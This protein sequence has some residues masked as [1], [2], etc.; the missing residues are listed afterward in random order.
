V[1]DEGRHLAP[2]SRGLSRIN[3][4][5]VVGGVLAILHAALL[6]PSRPPVAPMLGELMGIVVMPYL[7]M[8]AA[9]REASRKPARSASR[10]ISMP[11]VGAPLGPLDLRITDRTAK[12]IKA[13]AEWPDS[14]NRAIARLSGIADQGQMSKLLARLAKAGIAENRTTAAGSGEANCWRLTS[15]GAA[16][17]C[18]LNA[19]WTLAR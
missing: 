2:V 15:E 8:A 16:L 13:I 19:D 5:G 12:V 10:D 6:R 18:V 9:A 1:I 17:A 3:A 14:S 4:E 7:G 11:R